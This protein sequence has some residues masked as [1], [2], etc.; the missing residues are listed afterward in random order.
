MLFEVFTFQGGLVPYKA[1]QINF[2]VRVTS[3]AVLRLQ[4]GS[5]PKIMSGAPCMLR[6]DVL[7]PAPRWKNPSARLQ[8]SDVG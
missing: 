2:E 8:L 1:V 4:I 7:D 6:T 5:K 3:E